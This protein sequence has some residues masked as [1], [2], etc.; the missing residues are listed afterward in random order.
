MKVAL[1][2]DYLNQIGGAER[3]LAVLAEMFPK[4]P[5]YT[6]LH[7]QKKMRGMFSDREVKTSFLD[8]PFVRNHHRLFIPI[9]PHAIRTMHLGSTFDLIISDSAGFAK[10]IPHDKKTK[11]LS[12]CHTPLRYVWE[13]DTYFGKGLR[14]GVFRT[15]F[16]PLFGYVKKADARFAQ[17]PD[18]MLANSQFIA[19]KVKE[20]YDRD[21]EVVYPPVDL[22]VFH[23]DQAHSSR[24][25]ADSYFLAIGR[26]LPYK[27]FDLIIDAFNKNKLPLVIV[28]AGRE[29]SKLKARVKS[30]RIS[31]LPYQD[32]AKLRELYNGARALIF[33]Q[34][35]DF[36]LVAAEAIACGT[37][38][39]AFNG[40]GVKEI[41][42]DG[43]SGVLFD[44]QSVSSLQT[45]IDRFLK[46]TFDRQKIAQG[47]QRFSKDHFVKAIQ[48]KVDLVMRG[49]GGLA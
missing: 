29:E 7:D 3:V 45:A 48:A 46:M 41:V 42:Q 17:Y 31:F 5:I 26:F 12:Y 40:G 20:Y 37:P 47:A 23:P 2:H 28:G 25:K 8:L 38:V 15:T 32:D 30:D 4:A 13:T 16:K 18:L 9:M 21:A 49:Q 6:L 1:V 35:E 34:V 27:K 19:K 44:S 11:H 14:H 24:L 43:A 36:G 10:G 33:P 22:D 39:I